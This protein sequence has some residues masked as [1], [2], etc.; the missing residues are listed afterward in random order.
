MSFASDNHE[1][2]MFN[3]GQS[4]DNMNPSVYMLSTEN[5]N[6]TFTPPMLKSLSK[7]ENF[8]NCNKNILKDMLD[9]DFIPHFAD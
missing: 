6:P 9:Y 3:M 4:V 8:K 7:Q 5:Y 2:A 1:V